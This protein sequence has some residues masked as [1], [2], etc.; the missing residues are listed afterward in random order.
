MTKKQNLD[1]YT[2]LVTSYENIF[3]RYMANKL[4]TFTFCY[5]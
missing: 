3:I 5:I 1:L 4:K 2:L